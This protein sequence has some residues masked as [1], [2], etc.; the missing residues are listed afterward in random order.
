MP[1]QFD[2]TDSTSTLVTLWPFRSLPKRGFAVIIML[3]FALITVPVYPLLGTKLVWGLLPFL[4]LA[5]AALWWGLQRS[6]RDANII[7]ELTLTRDNAHLRHTDKHGRTQDW[8]CNIYWVR[9]EMHPTGGPVPFYVTLT[10]N[11]RMVEIG[12]FLSEEE[13]KSL[14]GEL[15]D[16]ISALARPG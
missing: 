12:A 4:M 16:S 6:Y 1:Y 10:G 7:E 11:G 13:R 2:R 9:V 8:T 5:V 3:C 14:Y 15:S